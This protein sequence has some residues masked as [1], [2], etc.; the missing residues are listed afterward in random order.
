MP[1][2]VLLQVFPNIKHFKRSDFLS[3]SHSCHGTIV[4]I[5]TNRE[6]SHRGISLWPE[7]CTG[8]DVHG[9]KLCSQVELK[10]LMYKFRVKTSNQI[11]FQLFLYVDLK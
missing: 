10:V 3:Y 9:V 1:L 11:F 4:T 2:L 8:A 6:V 5:G 7:V